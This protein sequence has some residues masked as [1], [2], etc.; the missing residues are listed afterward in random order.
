MDR[1][2]A[3]LTCLDFF[4]GILFSQNNIVMIDIKLHRFEQIKIYK[5]DAKCNVS[6]KNLAL[7]LYR[8]DAR[9]F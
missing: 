9:V 6:L 4:K 1:L 7:K 3:R 8:F 5:N 2:S